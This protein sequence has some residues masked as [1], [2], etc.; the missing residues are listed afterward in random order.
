LQASI[1][2]ALLPLRRRGVELKHTVLGRK[3]G[4]LA[5]VTKLN[6]PAA[7]VLIIDAEA[8]SREADRIPWA[9][10]GQPAATFGIAQITELVQILRGGNLALMTGRGAVTAPS[11]A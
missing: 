6:V 1:E 4:T 7:S 8:S 10:A 9:F 11:A 2:V 3:M 5:H